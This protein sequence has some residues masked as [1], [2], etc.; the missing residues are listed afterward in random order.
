MFLSKIAQ[1]NLR[2]LAWLMVL[3]LLLSIGS[4]V[5]SNAATAAANSTISNAYNQP[6]WWAKYQRL[7]NSSPAADPGTTTSIKVGTNVDVSNEK[8]PQSETAITLNPNNPTQLVA[9]SNEI[10]RLPMRG[11]FSSDS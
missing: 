10:N 3:A 2:P 9:G 11:Y 4:L 8:G 5:L 6:T 1:A 7:L